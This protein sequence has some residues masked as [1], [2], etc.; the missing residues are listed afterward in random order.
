MTMNPVKNLVRLGLIKRC[1]ARLLRVKAS[2][3]AAMENIKLPDDVA[4]ET[5]EI[6]TPDAETEGLPD[7]E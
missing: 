4:D 1:H 5:I 6:I 2:R 7:S 3:K